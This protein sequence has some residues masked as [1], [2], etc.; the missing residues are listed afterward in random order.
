MAKIFHIPYI[1]EK[2]L[3]NDGDKTYI[4]GANGSGKT[5][6]MGAMMDWCE[7]SGYNYSHYD[8]MAAL[9]EAPFLIQKSSDEDIIYSCKIMCELSL[10]FKD[11]IAG[12]AKAGNNHSFEQ[13]GDYM[14]DHILLRNVLSMAGTGYTRFFVLTMKAVLNP[15]AEY[16]FLDMP[17]SSLH[18]MLAQRVV[19]YLMAKFPYM[20]IIITTHSPSIIQRE[21]TDSGSLDM[22]NIIELPNG[23]I[24]EADDHHFNEVF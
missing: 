14:Q 16:Y 4:V 5:L 20:K 18:I 8:A 22:T 13:I 2:V 10:D 24:R 12:W 11:D 9:D 23:Y 19:G 15:T 1:N 7:D 6:L 3:W 17:E 21:Y